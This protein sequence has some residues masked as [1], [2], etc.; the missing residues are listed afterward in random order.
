MY[1][2]ALWLYFCMYLLKSFWRQRFKARD[3]LLYMLSSLYEL[4]K[5]VYFEFFIFLGPV[6]EKNTLGLIGF[7][8]LIQVSLV[9]KYSVNMLLTQGL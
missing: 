3:L 2:P 8:E 1:L 5:T 6:V 9:V 7:M 4:T